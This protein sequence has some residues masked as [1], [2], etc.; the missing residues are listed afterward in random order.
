METTWN[1]GRLV[2]LSLGLLLEQTTR[3][4]SVHTFRNKKCWLT[5]FHQAPLCHTHR[6][7]RE[8]PWHIATLSY[9]FTHW[10]MSYRISPCCSS[11]TD[12]PSDPSIIQPTICPVTWSL[13][14]HYCGSRT[15][16]SQ[17]WWDAERK[18][19]SAWRGC[20][21]HFSLGAM[22]ESHRPAVGGEWAPP[23]PLSQTEELTGSLLWG[24]GSQHYQKNCR[25][26]ERPCYGWREKNCQVTSKW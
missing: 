8:I 3:N 24:L 12:R 5:G 6:K 20:Q 11:R 19:S 4:H 1:P 23:G 7:I 2:R 9:L 17:G 16:R 15:G 18:R 26:S 10:C 13:H 22:T 14:H 21:V 25:D